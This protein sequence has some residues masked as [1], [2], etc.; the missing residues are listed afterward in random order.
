ML[1]DITLFLSFIVVVVVETR[2]QKKY[3]SMIDQHL[4]DLYISVQTSDCDNMFIIFCK[5]QQDIDMLI[6]RRKVYK[7]WDKIREK[8]SDLQ[9]KNKQ[10]SVSER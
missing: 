4:I 10:L 1:W 8:K 2:K 3:Q 5:T 6:W 9:S 7:E